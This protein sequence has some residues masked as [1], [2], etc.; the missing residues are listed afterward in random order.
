[1]L[2]VGCGTGVVVR[3][4]AALV[5]RRGRVSAVDTSAT[6]LAR[7]RSLSRG[8]PGGRIVFRRADGSRLPFGD[9]RFDVA[10][11]ITVICTS[12]IRCAW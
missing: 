10:L 11:A 12:R 1:V 6:L 3:D 4:L 8:A 9:G 5:G 2:E 7:A